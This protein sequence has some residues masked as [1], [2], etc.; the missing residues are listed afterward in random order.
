MGESRDS[1]EG[2]GS[3]CR[4][5]FVKH[6]GRW[7]GAEERGFTIFP[8]KTSPRDGSISSHSQDGRSVSVLKRQQS[9][10]LHPWHFSSIKSCR[11]PDGVLFLPSA[12][13]SGQGH[14]G[15]LATAV[16]VS[17]AGQTCSSLHFCSWG[18]TG[19]WGLEELLMLLLDTP[20]P[21]DHPDTPKPSSRALHWLTQ[22]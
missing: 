8:V 4:A 21:S 14:K 20:Q 5:E 13:T 22:L 15:P 6:P 11:V 16:P 1:C 17:C 9:P 3:P 10:Q 18:A 7:C 19:V 2:G 12:A